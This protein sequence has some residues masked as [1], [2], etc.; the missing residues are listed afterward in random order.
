MDTSIVTHGKR[1]LHSYLHIFIVGIFFCIMYAHR[2]VCSPSNITCS[3]IYR[4]ETVENDAFNL[5]CSQLKESIFHTTSLVL[6]NSTWYD[7]EIA[8]LFV[9][10]FITNN[11][12]LIL[13]KRLIV[14]LLEIIYAKLLY[15][16]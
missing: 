14:Q 2:Y 8:F 10:I 6:N 15:E 1:V 4:R 3:S 12:M 11:L 5:V 9:L 16:L 13:V 7:T